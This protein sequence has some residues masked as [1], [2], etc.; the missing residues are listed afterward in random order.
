MGTQGLLPWPEHVFARCLIL[1]AL[2]GDAPSA[3]QAAWRVELD[4][5]LE[6]LRIWAGQ[7]P[8]NFAHKH[9]LAAAEIARLDGR[10]PEAARLYQEAVE[11]AAAGGFVH[12][13]GMASERAA[14]F[15]ETRGQGRLASACWQRAYGSYDRWG[16][17][18]KLRA[19]EADYRDQL[20]RDLA[21]A[22]TPGTP[23][24]ESGQELGRHLVDTLVRQC[25][26][27]AAG[28]AHARLDNDAVRRSEEL[29]EATERLRVEIA[30]RKRA[31]D[32]LRQHRMRI[33]DTVRERTAELE[34]NRRQLAQAK[35][36]ALDLMEDAI[37]GR[38]QA[39][40]GRA[41]LERE[42]A[43]RTRVEQVL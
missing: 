3:R 42:V 41:A 11:S 22:A 27:W 8:E 43:E 40:A 5:M 16:A 13:E 6:Q 14:A 7:C 33:E 15:W 29:V 18:A 24:S 21:G 17:R 34:A 25:Q 12:W 35:A 10:A 32:Q 19:M 30:E 39:E 4:R 36:A 23:E 37:A 38:D 20:L 26:S 1:T 2:Y 9:A 28:V 31:E